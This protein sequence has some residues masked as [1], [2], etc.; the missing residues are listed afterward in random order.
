MTRL[1]H[2]LLAPLREPRRHDRD[3]GVEDRAR[4][5]CAEQDAPLDE[6]AARVRP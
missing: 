2:A 5:V 3:R 4:A 1:A 6:V